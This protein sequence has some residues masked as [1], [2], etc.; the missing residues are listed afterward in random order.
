MDTVVKPNHLGEYS[1]ASRAADQAAIR[2]YVRCTSPN[3]RSLAL[4]AGG[5]RVLEE[6]N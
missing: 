6:A 5:R 3:A 4:Y 1:E 2:F